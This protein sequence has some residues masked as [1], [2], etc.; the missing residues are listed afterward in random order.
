MFENFYKPSNQEINDVEWE[1]DSELYDL[2]L[3][4]LGNGKDRTL[5]I[6]PSLQDDNLIY[7]AVSVP[8]TDK[9]IV[10]CYEGDW[11]AK[12]FPVNWEPHWN[13]YLEL[14]IV[15]PKFIWNKNPDLD[16]LMT[17]ED[18][19][20]SIFEPSPWDCDY[21]LVWYLDPRV[22]PLPD[23]V[24]AMSCQPI[25]KEIKG[26]KD[27]GYLMPCLDVE[28]NELLP[29]LGID[30]DSSYPPFWELSNECAYELDPTHQVAS[31]LWVLKFTPSFR[32]PN[33]LK[34]LGI[35]SPKFKVEYNPSLSKLEYEI[36]YEIPWHDLNYE[37][38]WMLDRKHL[39]NGEDDIWAFKTKCILK[40]KGSKVVDY[41][42]P[43]IRIDHNPNLPDLEY[44]LDYVIPWH[45]LNYEH[46][47]MLDRKHLQNGEDDIW[48]F[49]TKCILKPKG[50]KVVGYISPNVTV[51]VNLD[52]KGYTFDID[53]TVPYHDLGFDHV[54]YLD[55]EYSQGYEIWAVKLH[56][57][58]N[59]KGWKDIGIINPSVCVVY[60]PDLKDLKVNVDYKIPYHDRNY[61]HVWYLD[62]VYSSGEKIWAAKLY[63][64]KKAKGEKEMGYVSP[65][66]PDR[67]DVVFISYNEPDEEENWARVLE[68]APWAKRVHGVK[69]IFEAHKAA[70]LISSTDMFYV[71][72]GDAY[73]VDDWEFDYQPGIFDRDCTYIWYSKN[74]INKF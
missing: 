6:N 21:K 35:V 66:F 15:K 26:V 32:K 4:Q 37:H 25:G 5:I 58:K 42:S 69:G 41:V 28:V 55:E 57:S 62:P 12:A 65:I 64:S 70:A 10:Y 68:K 36:D 30:I 71:V 27:M 23:K 8:D 16:K 60:N 2:K 74:S 73:L 13:A 29:E 50:S 48:A 9:C 72:D 22:N 43:D 54:W 51:E 19:P 53:Y 40:P 56:M 11:V 67:I 14:E 17:F 59:P 1:D 3:Y 7:Y 52:L 45:D 61:V 63:S 31:R 38:V 47:W 34:W 20:F 24:W 49:K 18:N 33:K 39:Q 44:N 46:V